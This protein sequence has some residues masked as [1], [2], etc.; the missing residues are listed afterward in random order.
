MRCYYTKRPPRRD[1]HITVKEKSPSAGSVVT[2]A[3]SSST[4]T[5]IDVVARATDGR[6]SSDASHAPPSLEPPSSSADVGRPAPRNYDGSCMPSYTICKHTEWY[7]RCGKGDTC[8]WA[9]SEEERTRW[10]QEARESISDPSG[11]GTMQEQKNL[12]AKIGATS[13]MRQ[14]LDVIEVCDRAL[15]LCCPRTYVRLTLYHIFL[16][17]R[18][19]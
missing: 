11:S 16:Y 15:T 12:N 3:S 7:G 10:N 8:T 13:N 1:L 5:D 17:T 18:P 4:N 2:A 6:G 9:H 19:T 14:V